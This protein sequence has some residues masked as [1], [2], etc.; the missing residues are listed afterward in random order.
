MMRM[1]GGPPLT[2]L[3]FA[4][5]A[6]LL[7]A[8]LCGCGGGSSAPSRAAG[9]AAAG[10]VAAAGSGPGASTAG[11]GAFRQALSSFAACLRQNGVRS[12]PGTGSAGGATVGLRGL[13]TTGSTYRKALAACKPLLTA[14]L[15][16]RSRRSQS[17]VAPTPTAPAAKSTTAPPRPARVPAAVTA[18]LM[19]FTSCMRSNGVASFPE[20][21]GGA[22]RIAGLHLDPSS[23]QYRAAEAKCNP[24]LQAAISKY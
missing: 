3:A 17:A 18:V 24:I 8:V 20:P 7:T 16:A 11:K 15:R 22:F 23:P 9:A 1:T 10:S 19:R 12:R 4:A 14:A 21:D 2:R 13:E 6:L 5:T